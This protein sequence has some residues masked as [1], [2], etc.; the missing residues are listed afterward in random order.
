MKTRPGRD[1]NLS[2]VND[3]EIGINYK[4]NNYIKLNRIQNKI[5][6]N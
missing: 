6:F 3:C 2:S 1:E 4:I 5:I